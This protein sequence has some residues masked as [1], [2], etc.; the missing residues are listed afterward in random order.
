MNRLR[1][2]GNEKMEVALLGVLCWACSGQAAE[3]APQQ[4]APVGQPIDGAAIHDHDSA[5]SLGDDVFGNVICDFEKDSPGRNSHGGPVCME[6]PNGSIVAFHTNASDH[7]L[8][9]WSEY[10]LSKDGGKTWEKYKKFNYSHQAY[11]K[12]P[13]RPAWVEEGLVTERGTIVLFVTHF[14]NGQRVKSVFMRSGDNGSTWTDDQLVD[15]EFVGYPAAVAVSGDTNYVLFDAVAGPH[16]LYVSTDDGRTWRK[17]STLTLEKSTWYGALCIMGDGRLLA[18]AY[19]TDDEDHLYY[20]ISEDQG[21]RWSQQQRA[22]LDKKIRD[23]ELAHIGGKYYLHGRS[24]HGGEGAHRFVL[25][26]SDDGRHWKSGV[27]VSGQRQGPDGY[28]HN[29]IIN[30]YDPDTPNELMIEYS[31]QYSGGDTNE[32]VFFVRPQTKSDR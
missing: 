4:M 14:E 6:Y 19:A 29:C 1:L 23:P 30:K 22:Y 18:G 31:I 21:Y 2:S 16:V 12:D 26:Q 32:Y 25:Y 3:H 20:C 15:G 13:N 5:T 8:D 27:V 7:N 24:G 17:R 9:G 11:L 10:A 28:S